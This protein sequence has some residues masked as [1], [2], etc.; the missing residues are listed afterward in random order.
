MVSGPQAALSVVDDIAHEGALEN[1]HLL[2]AARGD[3]LR[4]M[5]DSQRALAS[6]QRALS[7]ATN[8]SERRFLER[9]LT[10]LRA[11]ATAS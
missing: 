6:Y 2:H 3:F 1:Y 8:D 9:R 5:G 11:A 4:R 7:L 10:E